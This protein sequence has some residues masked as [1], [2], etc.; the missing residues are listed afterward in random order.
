M[1]GE[2]FVNKTAR[3]VSLGKINE[4]LTV[5]DVVSRLSYPPACL[6][7]PPCYH[8]PVLRGHYT[9]KFLLFVFFFFFKAI[10][11]VVA[12]VGFATIGMFVARFMRTVWGVKEMCRKRIWFQVQYW[13]L[14]VI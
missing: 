6:S 10:L 13:F 2:G 5:V 7:I 11:M 4:L 12:W 9:V 8:P 14:W 3:Q 1:K